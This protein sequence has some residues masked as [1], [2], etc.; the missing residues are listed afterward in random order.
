MGGREGDETEREVGREI[1]TEREVGRE[2][3][4]GG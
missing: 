3:Q 2:R 4:R 1:E